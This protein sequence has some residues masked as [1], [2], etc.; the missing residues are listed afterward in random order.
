MSSKPASSIRIPLIALFTASTAAV[1]VLGR[2]AQLC[3]NTL[4]HDQAWYLFAAQRDLDRVHLYGPGLSDTNPP[5]IIWLSIIPDLLARALHLSMV[6]SFRLIISLLILASVSWCIRL[7]RRADAPSVGSLWSLLALCVLFVELKV[8]PY[9]F[10]QREHLLVILTLPYFCAVAFE[11]VSK[12][13]S[14]ERCALGVAAAVAICLKPQHALVFVAFELVLAIWNRTLRRIISPELLAMLLTGAIYLVLVR[15]LT[16]L[17]TKEV[18]PLIIDTYW[19]Y[20]TDT[21]AS[22][23]HTMDISVA[24][25][26]AFIVCAYFLRRFLTFV[27]PIV[28]LAG[29]SLAATVSYS[30]QHVDW[31]YHAY[32]IDAFLTL[33]I[34]FLAVDLLWRLSRDLIS[35][36]EI[37]FSVALLALLTLVCVTSIVIAKFPSHINTNRSKLDQALSQYK[38][39]QTVYIFSTTLLPFAE[40]FNQGFTWGGRFPCLWTLPALIQNERGPSVPPSLF[41]SLPPDKLAQRST[42]QR[43]QVAEDLNLYRPS[44]VLVEQCTKRHPCQALEGKDFDMIPWFLQN[45]EFAAAWSHYQLQPGSPPRFNLYRRTF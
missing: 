31:A 4:G 44:V 32:P 3:R 33:A 34:L 28:A 29:C 2:I 39:P 45:P 41:K 35:V 26:S 15:V 23:L 30:I 11:S 19:A 25:A 9:D 43:L 38:T 20:A 16:P 1:M 7:F 8:L 40:V 14:L 5:L 24:L 27:L 36:P 21:T 12:L 42:T 13:P 18:I 37:P 10:G 22:L 6:V 17:Y